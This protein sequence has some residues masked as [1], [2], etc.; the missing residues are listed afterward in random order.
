MESIEF[1]IQRENWGSPEPW[2]TWAHRRDKPA[3]L[4]VNPSGQCGDGKNIRQK[5]FLL[6]AN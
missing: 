4:T 6:Q 5:L 3:Q 2:E 1:L